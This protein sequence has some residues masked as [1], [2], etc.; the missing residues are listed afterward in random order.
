MINKDMRR[1][2]KIELTRNKE[3]VK[4]LVS[5][6]KVKDNKYFKLLVKK[7]IVDKN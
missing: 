4:E 2:S 6:I 7:G 5:R 3:K 1:L